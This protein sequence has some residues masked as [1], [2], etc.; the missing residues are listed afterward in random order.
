MIPYP[1]DMLGRPLNVGDVIAYAQRQGNSST[2]TIRKITKIAFTEPNP[3]GYKPVSVECDQAHAKAVRIHSAPLKTGYISHYASDGQ[4][5]W[6]VQTFDVQF[7]KVGPAIGV[8]ENIVKLEPI[9]G[10]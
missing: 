5:M 7:S 9:S 10:P 8:L 6:H 2:Q 1:T 3:M 4:P